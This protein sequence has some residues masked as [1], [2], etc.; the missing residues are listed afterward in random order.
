VFLGSNYDDAFDKLYEHLSDE[1]ANS[2]YKREVIDMIMDNAEVEQSTDPDLTE[3]SRLT[4][5][6]RNR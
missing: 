1:F 3:D 6:E 5:E 2:R 4:L